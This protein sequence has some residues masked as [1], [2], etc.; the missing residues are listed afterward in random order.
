MKVLIIGKGGREHALADAAYRSASVDKVYAAPGSHGMKDV[1]EIVDIAADDING[2]VAF[3]KTEQIDLTI[4]GPEDTLA[5]GVVDAF[6]DEGLKIF[7]PNKA[8][9]RVESSKTFAKQLMEKYNI[10]TAAYKAFSNY[11]DAKAYVEEIGVPIVIKEDGLKAGKGV[12]VAYTIEEAMQALDIAFSIENNSVVIEECLVGFEFSLMSFVCGE[13]VIPMEI[14]QDH[15]CAYDGDKGPNTGGMGVYSPVKKITDDI[16]EETMNK[17]MRPMAKAMVDEGVPFVGFLYGGL[18]LTKD[19]VKTIEF[20]ARFGD[21]EAEVIL[22]RLKSDFAQTIL[23]VM[24]QQEVSLLWD[25]KV[26]LG[27]VMASE[28][29]PASSTK[30]AIIEGLDKVDS[31]IF[32]MGTAFHDGHY[33]TNGGR[34]LCVVSSADTIEEA[35]EKAYADVHK[36]TCDKLF[37]RNDIGKKDMGE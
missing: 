35:Y 27:V 14:A 10:P 24:N 28:N 29:Y 1:A 32:H 26:T 34:V 13:V 9:A 36:I 12:S 8:A 21:P 37:Y 11:D 30:G 4:V 6:Q 17:V 3:A 19:G 18:M 25:D 33:I 16:V 22:P 23:Q 7:G 5:L 20:N 2:L 31:R 15:K